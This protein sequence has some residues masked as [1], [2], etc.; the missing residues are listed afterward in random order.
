MCVES[1]LSPPGKASCNRPG[2]VVG[3]WRSQAASHPGG[4]EGRRGIWGPKPR[5]RILAPTELGQAS[6][7]LPWF[8]PLQTEII[9][10]PPVKEEISHRGQLAHE[11]APP[12]GSQ[13]GVG[14]PAATGS[15]GLCVIGEMLGG[16][17]CRGPAGGSALG[18]Q[19]GHPGSRLTCPWTPRKTG[20]F[21]PVTFRTGC[22]CICLLGLMFRP[23][24]IFLLRRALA[25]S[26]GGHEAGRIGVTVCWRM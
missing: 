13:P 18:P 21:N 6:S 12:R 23:S 11:P 25:S 4:G 17:R 15:C 20:G 19:A 10:A 7:A 24:N 2:P 5:S 26:Q 3:G 1:V 16:W 14:A 22:P 8:P 9:P